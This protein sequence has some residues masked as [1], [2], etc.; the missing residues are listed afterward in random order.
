M[1]KRR[2]ISDINDFKVLAPLSASEENV[3][4]SRRAFFGAYSEHR[5]WQ[6]SGRVWCE[7]LS[8]LAIGTLR[9]STVS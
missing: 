8:P 1:L 5:L 9:G 7:C 4:K 3:M 2:E 6:G